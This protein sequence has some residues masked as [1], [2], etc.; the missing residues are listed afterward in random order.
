MVF[1]DFALLPWATVAD[2]VA[3]GLELR[4]AERRERIE[5][6]ARLIDAVGLQGFSNHYPHQL[7][8]GM[9]QRVGLARALAID[10]QILLLDEPF[11]SLDSVT[12]GCFK[13]TCSSCISPRGKRS[14]S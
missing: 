1:Q 4:G 14:R 5:T 11:G 3:F 2:N 7:S 8:G 6:A 9:Q 13:R 10:P 12:G